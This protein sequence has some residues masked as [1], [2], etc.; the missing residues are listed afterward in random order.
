MAK[1]K[2][3]DFPLIA[4]TECMDLPSGDACGNQRTVEHVMAGKL[5]HIR[6]SQENN[7]YYSGYKDWDETWQQQRPVYIQNNDGHRV[8]RNGH[9]RLTMAHSLGMLFVHYTDDFNIGWNQWDGDDD[10]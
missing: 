5:G 8:F 1:I 6:A 4:I 7:P 2:I 10:E 9:H 3:Q